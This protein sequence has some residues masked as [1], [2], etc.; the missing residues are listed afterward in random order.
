[1]LDTAFGEL[2]LLLMVS[3]RLLFSL[4][5]ITITPSFSCVMHMHDAASNS[6]YCENAV[7]MHCEKMRKTLAKSA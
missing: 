6:K 4:A 2:H 3:F 7:K 1:M 5:F